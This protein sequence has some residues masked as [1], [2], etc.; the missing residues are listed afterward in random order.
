MPREGSSEPRRSTERL[1]S[2]LGYQI[3]ACS[4]HPG[5][6]LD[7][8][9][10][11]LLG[12]ASGKTWSTDGRREEGRSQG[13]CLSLPWPGMGVSRTGMFPPWLLWHSPSPF[14]PR[15]SQHTPDLTPPS[16]GWPWRLCSGNVTS[17]HF[18]FSSRGY[19]TSYGRTER[20]MGWGGWKQRA[21]PTP[22]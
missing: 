7:V 12:Q 2:Q 16:A 22:A 10:W 21:S 8:G 18:F 4:S 3:S 5:Q 15:S 6:A 20:P 19:D 13:I 14:L 17:S 9:G 11:V 1:G